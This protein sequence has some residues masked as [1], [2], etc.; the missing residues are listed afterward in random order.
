[1]KTWKDVTQALRNGHSVVVEFKKAV[2]EQ[3]GYL[4]ARMRGRLISFTEEDDTLVRF[5][6]DLSE[7][8]AYNRP[9]ESSNYWDKSGKATL[10]AREAGYYPEDHREALYA[11]ENAAVTDLAD[12]VTDDKLGLYSE[13]LSAAPGEAYTAWLESQVKALRRELPA[14]ADRLSQAHPDEWGVVVA[15]SAQQ[16][17]ECAAGSVA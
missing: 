15:R 8:D 17:K 16:L 9:F 1:M 2:E 5:V 11:D 3:E 7:F 12:I 14:I 6:I 13:F 10:T 4:E